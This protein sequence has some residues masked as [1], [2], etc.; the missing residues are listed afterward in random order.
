MQ[1]LTKGYKMKVSMVWNFV[2]AGA[3]ALLFA[4][5]AATPAA[6]D[7]AAPQV[8]SAAPIKCKT[9]EASTGTAIVR[10]DCSG[11][12]NVTSIDARDM[13]GS[14]RSAVPDPSAGR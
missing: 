8:A 14:K 13:M 10:K 6:T 1:G 5:C 3:T 7:S 2:L 11:N 4:G 12:P 9:A